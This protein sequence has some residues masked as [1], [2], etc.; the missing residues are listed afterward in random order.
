MS[1]TRA[2]LQARSLAHSHSAITNIKAL[3][4]KSKP[5]WPVFL[6]GAAPSVSGG[7]TLFI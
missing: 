7:M 1:E 3:E 6:A 2:A 5:E 4:P